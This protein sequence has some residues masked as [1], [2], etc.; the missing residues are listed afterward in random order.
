MKRSSL[1]L[2]L[3]LLL[4]SSVGLVAQ[5]SKVDAAVARTKILLASVP[6]DQWG[7]LLVP[8]GFGPFTEWT[9]Q[10]SGQPIQWYGGTEGFILLPGH[11]L[12]SSERR[13]KNTSH[14]GNWRITDTKRTSG[15]T[16]LDV[17]P[18]HEYLLDTVDGR[19]VVIDQSTKEPWFVSPAPPPLP[20]AANGAPS[21]VHLGLSGLSLE[22]P[23]EE[24][25][26]VYCD[27]IPLVH[28]MGRGCQCIVRLP[29]GKHVWFVGRH[30]LSIPVGL[31]K[32]VF[33]SEPVELETPGNQEL[34][35]RVKSHGMF[36]GKFTFEWTDQAQFKADIV[37]FKMASLWS[38]RINPAYH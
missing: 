14:A 20:P 19:N 30:L 23:T 34:Y 17:I 11:H 16:D 24:D 37:K 29:P 18:G 3:S 15:E 22:N 13:I 25:L 32:S 26:Y 10:I 9:V 31:K 7:I 8:G 36:I 35:L 6:A 12:I 38:G 5:E 27:R 4:S 1:R 2:V 33:T 21:G 28:L